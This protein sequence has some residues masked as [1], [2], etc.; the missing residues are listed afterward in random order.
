M[1]YTFTH[2]KYY[3]MEFSEAQRTKKKA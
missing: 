2:S 1:H 3:V